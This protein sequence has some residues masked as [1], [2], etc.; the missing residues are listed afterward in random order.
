[1]EITTT[2][3]SAVAVIALICEYVD[4]SIGMGYG[5]TLTPL[6]LIMGFPPLQVVPSVLLGQLAGGLVGSFFHHRVGNVDFDFRQDEAI[7]KK[8]R[9]LGYLPKSIDSKVVF[10]LA[11]CGIVGAL[12]A[13]SFAI[14]IPTVVLYTYIG[15]MVLGIG[16]VI[17]LRRNRETNFS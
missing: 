15:L 2:I 17:L 7:K 1:M 16:M 11:S 13:V 6:L 4:A 3:F 9:G 5:T 14:N 8:L 10:I 12:G